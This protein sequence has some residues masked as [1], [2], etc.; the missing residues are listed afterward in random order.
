[1]R[2]GRRRL[3][4]RLLANDQVRVECRLHR[5]EPERVEEDLGRQE[6]LLSAVADDRRL[7][8][9]LLLDAEKLL[10]LCRPETAANALADDLSHQVSRVRIV[11]YLADRRDLRVDLELGEHVLDRER[12][13]VLVEVFRDILPERN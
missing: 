1:R 4:D 3:R 11:H 12:A 9:K 2:D 5:T 7:A 13:A 6:S 8:R 10:T